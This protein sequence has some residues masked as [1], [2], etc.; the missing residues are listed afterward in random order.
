MS[1]VVDPGLL[2]VMP[3]LMPELAGWEGSA[4]DWLS[5]VDCMYRLDHVWSH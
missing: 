1:L 3:M 5:S 4:I 2:A